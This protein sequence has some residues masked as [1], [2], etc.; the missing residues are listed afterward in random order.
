MEGQSD[1]VMDK[2]G[3]KAETENLYEQYQ[4][5]AREI[6]VIQLLIQGYSYQKI[7]EEL[8]ISFA[9]ARTHGYN[10]YKKAGVSNKV[11]LVNLMKQNNR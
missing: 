9:T 10:I 6:E 11:E 8:M 3:E 2:T 1:A 5:T 7:S 4:F